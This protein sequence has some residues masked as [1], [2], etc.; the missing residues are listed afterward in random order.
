MAG[1]RT[2]SPSLKFNRNVPTITLPR[3]HIADS[4]PK[5]KAYEAHF[6]ISR[7]EPGRAGPAL[8]GG[9]HHRAGVRRAFGGGKL[10]R[11]VGFC[12]GFRF[13]GRPDLPGAV[14]M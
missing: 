2:D 1:P 8:G 10:G 5:E 13:W 6:P 7:N 3:Y 12:G 14:K 11:A 9:L 4:F